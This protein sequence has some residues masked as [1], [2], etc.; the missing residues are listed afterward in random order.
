[1]ATATYSVETA[2][3]TLSTLGVKAQ[4]GIY[5]A[6]QFGVPE[7]G[8][9]G[10]FDNF[11]VAPSLREITF[12]LD[13]LQSTGAA[14]IP[15]GGKEARPSTPAPVTGTLAFTQMNK[16]FT[17]SKMTKIVAG[18]D[19]KAFL[20]PQFRYQAECAVRAVRRKWGDNFYGFSSGIQ[21][22]ASAINTD[23]IVLKDMYTITGQ[24]STA[25]NRRCADLFV[26]GDYV[27]VLNPS[28]P[29]LR[30]SGIVKIDT[31]TRST[32]TITGSAVSDISS[33]QIGDYIVFANNVENTTLAGG[34]E[35]NLSTV[36]LL[37]ALTSTSLHGVSGTTYSGWNASTANTSGGR[38]T[39]VKFMTLAQ[40]IENEGGGTMNRIILSQGC[41]R[42]IVDL[43][44]AGLRFTDAMALEMD[45]A[46]KA[47]G[48]QF[49]STK[50][51]PDGWVIG[52]D[53]DNSLKRVVVM[54]QPDTPD[55]VND[56]D[57]L[58]DDSGYVFDVDWLVGTGCQSRANMGYYSNVTQS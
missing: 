53:L 43:Q 38:F 41:Y 3:S 32:N 24:G 20:K 51:V 1:M 34:T 10:K 9:Y 22:L 26:A 30:T 50:R 58:Q 35:Y 21:C 25:H 15:E 23:D 52:L 14:F 57:K 49:L 13:L 48:V 27:A 45:G 18:K 39:P 55:S 17:L 44:R 2:S 12:E 6:V 8:W 37:D 40:N 29:A 54:P 47:D 33:P 16:R 19:P 4:A 7:F 31:V 28:G 36:G 42:D 5:Q 56:G 11:N 46:P